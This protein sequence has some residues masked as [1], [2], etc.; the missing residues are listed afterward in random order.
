[1]SEAKARKL[2]RLFQ[3]NIIAG[4]IV[5]VISVF[6]MITGEYE[7]LA[8]REQGESLLNMVGLGSMLYA[9]GF[10]YLIV[11]ANPLKRISR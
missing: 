10:W 7:N 6:F 11:L 9:L 8:M 2:H 5:F 3:F 1:M 4:V